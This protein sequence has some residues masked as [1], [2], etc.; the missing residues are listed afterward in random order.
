M[1]KQRRSRTGF[2]RY[3]KP[4]HVIK[5]HG[6]GVVPTIGRCAQDKNKVIFETR[7]LAKQAC[8]RH[9]MDHPVEPYRC[10]MNTDWWHI[11]GKTRDPRLKYGTA[12]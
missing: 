8:K 3:D 4:V 12:E 11:G 10:A 9:R 2:Y 1:G 6:E 7:S 5:R